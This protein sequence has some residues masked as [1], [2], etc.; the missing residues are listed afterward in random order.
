VQQTLL[1]TP[2]T[3]FAFTSATTTI[4]R[5]RCRTA[6]MDARREPA[7]DMS[8][9]TSAPGM[10]SGPAASLVRSSCPAGSRPLAGSFPRRRPH[11]PGSGRSKGVSVS[12]RT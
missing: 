6:S 3:T 7:L 1:I 4:K 2:R 12:G 11:G 5:V 8:R 9:S 10:V